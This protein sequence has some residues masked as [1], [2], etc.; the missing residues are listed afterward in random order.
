M[1]TQRTIRRRAA[2]VQRLINESETVQLEQQQH[3]PPAQAPPLPL[4]ADEKYH[5]LVSPTSGIT[6]IYLVL[7]FVHFKIAAA[8]SDRSFKKFVHTHTITWLKNCPQV[9][10][11]AYT[12]EKFMKPLLKEVTINI[13]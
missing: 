9:P 11:T 7:L 4:L 2:I 6:L 13:Q 8:L 3:P 12:L 1:P 5:T 10:A